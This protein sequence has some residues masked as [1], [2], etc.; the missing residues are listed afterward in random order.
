VS[1][2]ALQPRPGL[3]ESITALEERLAAIEGD[4]WTLDGRADTHKQ[5]AERAF[6]ELSALRDRVA[7]AEER[8]GTEH[9]A[10]GLNA[11]RKRVGVTEE[12]LDEHRDILDGHAARLTALETT[13]DE[14]ADEAGPD[15][16]D[17]EVHCSCCEQAQEDRAEMRSRLVR[18]EQERNEWDA[19]A[20]EFLTR[21]EQAEAERD[22]A[23]R[24]RDSAHEWVKHWRDEADRHETG[25]IEAEDRSIAADEARD[26]M[27]HARDE[28][29]RQRDRARD[30]RDARVALPDDWR[31]QV[32]G[33]ASSTANADVM[34]KVIE[35]WMGG[36]QR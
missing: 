28:A 3:R 4:L 6:S 21:T 23:F 12:R 10:A 24:Q 20:S 34:T 2:P 30:E 7:D 33:A 19:N 29:I 31:E 1:D 17:A 18:A 32:A 27:L 13:S 14:E 8:L 22:E 15:V 9:T 36:E 26:R 35:Q 5:A 16:V 25:R 11:V